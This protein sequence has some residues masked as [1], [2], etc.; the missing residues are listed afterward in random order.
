MNR[1]AAP[2]VEPSSGV[3]AQNPWPGLVAFTEELHEFFHGRADEADELR[4][5]MERASLT[6]LFG[7]SGLGKSSLLQAG[8]FPLLRAE[9]YLP[10]SIRL[11][12][13]AA[14]PPLSQQVTSTVT[15]AL[16]EAGG[17]PD[18]APQE[19]GTLWEHFH[20]RRLLLQTEDGRPL[21]PVLVF[22]QFEEMFAIGHA[23]AETRLRAS[24]FLAELADF[25]EN[26][27]PKSLERRLDESPELAR[28][29]LFDDRDYR[30]L[31]SFREDYLPQ[32]EGLR[33]LMPSIA[34]N[35]MRLTRMNGVRALEAVRNPGGDLITPE[36]AQQVVAFVAGGR[37]A[38]D[39]AADLEV[40]PSLLSLVCRE[41]NNRRLALGLPQI[42]ADLLAGN[43]ERILQDFYE[44]CVADQPPEVRSFVEDELVTDSGVRENMA[45]ERARKLLAQRGAPPSAIDELVKRR[46]LHLEDRLDIQRVELTHDVLTSVVK[47]SR[48]ERHQREAALRS[49]REAQESRAKA[50]VQRR[51]FR[52]VVA[53]M[54]VALAVVSAFGLWSYRLY[55]VSQERLFEA[56]RQ[57][58]EAERQ[59]HEAEH[60]KDRAEQSEAAARGARKEAEVVKEVFDDA[61]T[62]VTEQKV[63]H[64]PGLSPVHEELARMQL[65]SLQLLAQKTHDDPTIEPKTAR[66]H[67]LLGLIGTYAGSFKPAEE[68][69]TKAI[70][71]YGRL[72]KAHPDV[73]DYRL[74]ECRALLDLGYLHWDDNRWPAARRLCEQGLARLDAEHAQSP[75]N[76]Q[77]NYELGVCLIRLGGCLFGA[78]TQATREKLATR[79]IGI[80]EDLV[81]RQHRLADSLANLGVAKYR[82]V[83]ARFDGKDQAG[84]LK[85]LD[86]IAALDTAALTMDADSPYFNSNRV[87]LELDRSDALVQLGRLNEALKA[88]EAAVAVARE[89]VTRSPDI[90]RYGSLLANSLKTLAF[91]LRRV[92]READARAA[93]EESI[94]VIDGLVRR[95]PDRA[96]LASRWFDLRS[97]LAGF[98][99]YGP[100]PQGEIQ[101]RQDLLH[102]LDLTVKRGREL[103]AA[104]PDHHFLQVNYAKTLASRGRYEVD[105]RRHGQALPF[106]LEGVEVYRTRIL[107]DKD[108]ADADDINAYLSQLQSAATCASALARGDEIIRLSRLALE[109]H[110]RT[111]YHDA[112]DSV[113]YILNLA[114]G[115]HRDAGRLPQAI[116]AYKL[117]IDVRRPAYES[118]K[119]HW[120]LHSNLGSDYSQLADTYRLAKDYRNEVLANREYLKLIVGPWWN[121]RIDEYVDTDR[122]A[123]KAEADRI[124]ALIKS[125]LGIGSKQ[126]TI[127]SDFSGIRYPFIV[128]ITNV[129]W[130]KHPL[131]DQ[132]RWLNET[133]GGTVPKDLMDLFGR[134]NK[135]AHD[136]NQRLV[137]V[138]DKTFFSVDA[139]GAREIENVAKAPLVISS[140]ATPDKSGA[141]PLLALQARLV[142][143]K[144][145]LTQS[146]G[147]SA[148]ILDA[149]QA[150][151]D[152]GL[153][154]LRSK[155]AR[156]AAD[157]LHDSVRLRE[158]LARGQPSGAE[159][160]ERL[161][162]TL[163]WLGKAHVQ[164]KDLAAAANCFLRRLDLLQQLERE[165]PS[166]SQQAAIAETHLMFGELADL[167][168]DRAEALA[169]FARAAE[170]ESSQAA[171]K[172]GILLQ[173]S[174][175]MADLL[176]PDLKAAYGRVMKGG[177]AWN[178]STFL[179]SFHRE[180]EEL[181]KFARL[182]RQAT[183]S[184]TLAGLYE[185]R[186]ETD[187][188]RS[189]LA[190]EYEAREDQRRL[191]ATRADTGASIL[192][193]SRLARSYLD[194]KKMSDA[195]LWTERAAVLGHAASL[196]QFADWCEK[197]EFVKRDADKVA[198]YR[199]LG[200]RIRGR[201]SF[202]R[203]RFGEALPDLKAA[204]DSTRA[205]ADD[206]DELGMCFGK[207]DRWDEAVTAYTRSIEIDLKTE[208]AA[209]VVCNLMEALM[210]ASRP[211]QLLK[212]ADSVTDKGWEPPKTGDEAARFTALF[213]GFRAAALTASGKDASEPL[214]AMRAITGKPGFKLTGWTWDET[215]HWLK[216]T[217]L[218]PDRRT[219]V[220]KILTEL[221]GESAGEPKR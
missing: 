169:W 88:S 102:T 159:Q 115:V 33:P 122:P 8:L 183:R 162:T 58:H 70:E 89:I 172:V 4:R 46:L 17:Q 110:A 55:Q 200:H 81:K 121:T 15:R 137:D 73:L 39:G 80:Y 62:P 106:L 196:L 34:E 14:A 2:E 139:E 161:V 85:S 82:L 205:D 220:E 10:V 65:R 178:R 13:A 60:Q 1:L 84:L 71:L 192:A 47:K 124:R 191:D 154:R 98:F 6:V 44:R 75:E 211:E 23:S 28:Q 25:V 194:D 68:H 165:R 143:L 212:F 213:H 24:Q 193:A 152:L 206:F 176:T 77:V 11:D 182:G 116:E 54:A 141:D 91:D 163:T 171:N 181:W 146:P 177:A 114:A 218:A 179:A 197:G 185:V 78:S 3:D 145:K 101:A 93:F 187:A 130:P 45:L 99:E 108:M 186:K 155:Q 64:M 105:G 174:V 170:E 168:G 167:R 118:A 38:H 66:A 158:K 5:R 57:R 149:A 117:A 160:R 83:K 43:R 87:F 69:L 12:H 210:C 9:G 109:V 144:A 128:Y 198:R 214:R 63:R 32:M 120:Y 27:A 180:V 175:E 35:R 50:R 204:C 7:Q 147:D 51:R 26:R 52:A 157:A 217:K 94:Q 216:T 203:R 90:S 53:G 129:A 92:K 18:S 125:A 22:D 190:K 184:H 138:C 151:E 119:W 219:A 135:Q 195:A 42:T 112:L 103:A 49:E 16:V 97:Y 207:L 133:S 140:S 189:A 29:F 215:N 126:F 221:K 100:K 131:E 107:P 56:E 86:E 156:E 142:E 21:R 208:H 74:G 20:R 134:L 136:N 164:L 79:A 72:A 104:F 96:F 201:G 123:D 19:T 173:S 113:G 148:A 31:V 36:V 153:H 209:G 127:A 61:T 40:E 166:Q 150:F 188:F 202:A 48:D 111:K 59:R 199:Y 95:F 41:L 132:A 30:V 37:G 67:A 76:P